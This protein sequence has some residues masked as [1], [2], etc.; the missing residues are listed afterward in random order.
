MRLPAHQASRIGMWWQR[1]KRNIRISLSY[2]GFTP[3]E[4]VP[5]FYK[6][7]QA[8]KFLWDVYF[9]GPT[10]FDVEAKKAGDISPIRPVFI[11]PEVKD[12][13]AWYGGFQSAFLD[14]ERQFIF[15][16]QAEIGAQ[17]YVNREIVTG[18][19]AEYRGSPNRSK[20]EGQDR[21]L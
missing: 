17:A 20:M 14:K 5:R 19:R 9:N 7:R 16:F 8:N 12:E 21:R 2:Q 4:F 10:T 15:S 1:L 18:E 6:E 3:A 13:K 11:L